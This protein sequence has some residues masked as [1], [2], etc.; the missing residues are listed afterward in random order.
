[1]GVS[2]A[3]PSISIQLEC[4]GWLVFQGTKP[5]EQGAVHLIRNF[6]MWAMTGF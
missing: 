6:V 5:I 1:M 3:Q 4:F 2:S